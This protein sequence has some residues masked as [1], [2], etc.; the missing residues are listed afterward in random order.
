MSIPE[1]PSCSVKPIF[2]DE[3][4]NIEGIAK[5]SLEK[6]REIRVLNEGHRLAVLEENV[7]TKKIKFQP[8]GLNVY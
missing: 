3:K 8:A 2:A 1:S 5:L 7:M 6:L 4:L